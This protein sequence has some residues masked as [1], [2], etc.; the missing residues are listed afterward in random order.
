VKQW[1]AELSVN[2]E[3][4]LEITKQI[5]AL[6][7]MWKTYD[8][9]KEIAGLLA[10]MPK[11]KTSPSRPPSQG[12]T[13]EPANQNPA[14]QEPT[15]QLQAAHQAANQIVGVASQQQSV[16]SHAQPHRA[17]EPMSS[18]PNV[19]QHSVFNNEQSSAGQPAQ[20]PRYSAAS[21]QNGAMSNPGGQQQMRQQQARSGHQSQASGYSSGYAAAPPP[22][23][24]R[25]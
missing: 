5:L 22:Y 17:E 3:T 1:F 12:P 24:Q 19:S 6:Y 10:K 20:Q 16:Q 4:I 13:A 18:R 8:E 15:N 14:H 21:V 23:N 11:P 7:E 25:H 9:K 2:M